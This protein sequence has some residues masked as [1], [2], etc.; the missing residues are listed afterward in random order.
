MDQ[1]DQQ[2]LLD[3]IT[4]RSEAAFAEI[5][6]RHVD[7][8]YSAALRM[9]CDTHL[10]EDVTQGAFLALAQHAGQLAGRP[11]L[12]GWL[13]RTAQNLA[14]N[15]VR[16]EVRR[17]AREQEAVAMNPSPAHETD[18]N[19]ETIAPDLDAALVELN[20]VE[21]D[22]LLLR[23]FERKSAREMAGILGLSE[24]A[25]QKR[26]SRAVERLREWFSKRHVTVGAG[27][28]AVIIS[29]NAVQAAPVGL[30]VNICTAALTGTAVSGSTTVAAAKTIAMTTLQK[31]VVGT[32]LVAAVGTGIYEAHQARQLRE[33]NAALQ[34]QVIQ[35]HAENQ[36]L[37]V[38]S[39]A[40][41]PRLPAPAI[42]VAVLAATNSPPDNSEPT[43]FWARFK[44]KPA[45]ITRE[46]AESFL[47][48]NG[49]NAA[50]LL[51]AYRTSRDPAL[52]EEAMKKFP[53][54]PQVAFEV[55]EAPF[56]SPFRLTPEEQRQWLDAFEKSA[57]NNSLANYLSAVNYFNA[58]QI[59]E[60]VKELTAA[61]GKTLD[62]YTVG[63]AEND[64]EAYLAAGYSPAEAEQMGTSQL[65]L[66]QLAQ[67]KNLTRQIYDLAGAYQQTGDASSAQAV[68]L[69]AD[70]LGQQYATPSPGE[71]TI[72]QLV[73]IAIE[74][75]A[76][77]ALDPNLPYGD[78]GQTVQDRLNQLQE[79]KAN[80]QQLNDQ[81]E[82]LIPRLAPQDLIIYKNRWLMF[83]EQNA[84]Q[85]VIS[86]YGKP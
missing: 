12:S 47:N 18:A 40:M 36:Q 77:K 15:T 10:A 11:V 14:A 33:Q 21:R 32:A 82:N 69:M 28:L 4:R 74:N 57:P 6:R 38:E 30:A 66:P 23:Y 48:A 83:G 49:R 24:G 1:T 79:Q 20:D 37:A 17:R 81:V 51:A 75:I 76:L 71:P 86:K 64:I 73:G 44:N 43:N 80:L 35:L 41:T 13:H 27:G 45:R 65:L 8:V 55:A 78:S 39:S 26:V 68:L 5:V 19:W 7:L 31:I 53:N 63:R 42:Q 16:S 70:A 22:A 67:L 84:E 72:T 46:Q 60:G 62:D 61:S 25:A 85:W 50:N 56:S 58:G 59:D 52:L 2:L 54:D 9:V 29:A 3:Y 34:A